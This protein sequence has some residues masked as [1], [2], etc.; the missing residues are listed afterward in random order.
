MFFVEVELKIRYRIGFLSL[1]N[2]CSS[3]GGTEIDPPL[4]GSVGVT[5]LQDT[6]DVCLP[7]CR[8]LTKTR[9]R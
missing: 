9:Y 4:I 7:L 1:F 6:C 2:H 3:G 8:C 5:P